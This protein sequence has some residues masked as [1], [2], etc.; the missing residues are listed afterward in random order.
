MRVSSRSSCRPS[1]RA[2][3]SRGE[4]PLHP[5]CPPRLGG[6]CR[7]HGGRTQ[8][9]DL[10]REPALRTRG[11]ATQ[12][13][14]LD[15][16][17]DLPRSA[18]VAVAVGLAV[19]TSSRL[20]PSAIRQL[21]RAAR[22]AGRRHPDRRVLS[23]DEVPTS[24]ADSRQ[25]AGAGAGRP[26]VAG[27]VGANDD[28]PQSHAEGCRHP[29]VL[30]RRQEPVHPEAAP[31]RVLRRRWAVDRSSTPQSGLSSAGASPSRRS[32]DSSTPI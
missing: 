2:T 10:V 27:G 16:T 30:Q 29:V 5:G 19:S 22:V 9:D 18:L 6:H 20:S 14:L 24:A 8:H 15:N 23:G 4:R 13:Y 12:Q 11:D 3:R 26:A 21:S 1:G 32:V 25:R 7:R 31:C 28:A 17:S